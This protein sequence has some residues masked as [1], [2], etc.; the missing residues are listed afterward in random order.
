[1][2]QRLPIIGISFDV[3]GIRPD[4]MVMTTVNDRNMVSE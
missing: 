2:T 4:V 3:V 1:M